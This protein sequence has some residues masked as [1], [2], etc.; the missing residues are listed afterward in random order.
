MKKFFAMLLVLCMT[1]SLSA[2]AESINAG[3]IDPFAAPADAAAAAA[4][5]E[6]PA[7][8]IEES[9][10]EAREIV[11]AAEAVE[12]P[13]AESEEEPVEKAAEKPVEE[14]DEGEIAEV[15]SDNV[16]IPVEE[17]TFEFGE[18]ETEF[19]SSGEVFE[20]KLGEEVSFETEGAEIV[21]PV[22]INATNFPDLVFRRY[23]EKYFKKSEN[24]ALTQE[25]LEG[26][27]ELDTDDMSGS[28][29]D[30]KGIEYFTKLEYLWI[31]TE[32]LTKEL[33]LDISN[34]AELIQLG[35]S[36]PNVSSIDVSH[37]PKLGILYVRDTS[38]E[39]LDVSHNSELA[40]LYIENNGFTSVDVRNCPSLQE[41][42]CH[43]NQLTALDLS[44]N[45]MLSHLDCSHN[46]IAELDLSHNPELRSLKVSDNQ[47]SKLNLS[48][49]TKLTNMYCEDNPL[50]ALDITSCPELVEYVRPEN[51]RL[52]DDGKH[53][54]YEIVVDEDYTETYILVNADVELTA[55]KPEPSPTETSELTPEPT[56]APTT[57]KVTA[58]TPAQTVPEAPAPTVPTIVATKK[59]G[60]TTVSAAPGSVYQLD[61]GGATG[62]AFKSSK[63]KIATVNK[64]GVVTIKKAGKTKITFKVGKKKR[65]VTLTVK[66]PTA[67]TKVSITNGKTVTLHKGE[68]LQLGAVLVPETAVSGLRWK[69]SKKK[70]ASVNANGVVTAKK[71]GKTKI[72]VKTRN[73]KKAVITVKVVKSAATG[74]SGALPESI[75]EKWLTFPDTHNDGQSYRFHANGTYDL[76]IYEA[77]GIGWYSVTY[78]GSLSVKKTADK[79]YRLELG[80]G[81]KTKYE[82]MGDYEKDSEPAICKAKKVWLVMPG[83]RKSGLSGTVLD[84]SKANI[85]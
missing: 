1:L 15:V 31:S 34:N 26:C 46:Q 39:S 53:V 69:S 49:N 2:L 68:T 12:V 59:A 22:Q 36:G 81:S 70:V 38:L 71:K 43:E 9:A 83:G 32:K 35:I 54:A 64:N 33:K 21:Y 73:G 20:A 50:T 82:G 37:N 63:K 16:D 84:I 76:S 18:E 52:T 30:F 8:L 6:A 62:K 66:D 28:V 40:Y 85:L 75:L 51:Y 3:P 80:K 57:P 29:A 67:P 14:S 11:A 56:P 47:L 7:A 65:T 55:V 42:D 4:E 25:E 60:K 48:K 27:T 58:P 44:Q 5:D 74:G 78:S 10:E 41:F 13:T 19:I 23:I 61:L 77:S 17:E 24:D 79:V 72:T 45:A